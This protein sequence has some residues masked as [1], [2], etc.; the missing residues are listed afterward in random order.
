MY[1]CQKYL[2]HDSDLKSFLSFICFNLCEEVKGLMVQQKWE[3]PGMVVAAQQMLYVLLNVWLLDWT[4]FKQNSKPTTAV[5]A[6]EVSSLLQVFFFLSFFF[7]FL[8]ILLYSF[9]FSSKGHLDVLYYLEESLG[10]LTEWHERQTAALCHLIHGPTAGGAGTQGR[11]GMGWDVQWGP[12]ELTG[13]EPREGMCR[14]VSG[15]KAWKLEALQLGN[16]E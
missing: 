3:S 11:S 7:V 12:E 1:F 10:H 5:T 14:N 6:E 8:K 13:Q 2:D 16:W 4:I 15:L 9:P